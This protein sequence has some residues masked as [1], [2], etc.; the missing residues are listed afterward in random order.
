[1]RRDARTACTPEFCGVGGWK[2]QECASLGKAR[3]PVTFAD[4]TEGIPECRAGW[5]DV[6]VF[7]LYPEHSVLKFPRI[8]HRE[9]QTN[10]IVLIMV[11]TLVGH[12]ETRLKT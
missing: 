5:E 1:M 6:K 3:A 10:G 4:D 12:Q 7:R 8:S 2:A 9:D 11:A